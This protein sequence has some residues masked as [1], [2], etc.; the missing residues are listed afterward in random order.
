MGLLDVIFPNRNKNLQAV[1]GYFQTLTAYNPVFTSFEGG[2]YEVMQTRAAIHAFALHCSKLKPEIVGSRNERLARILQHKPNPYMNTAQFLYRVATIYAATN[3]VFIAP[4]YGADYETIIGYYPLSPDRV[5]IVHVH[6]KPYLRYTFANGQKAAVELE[7]A[8]I[9]T[10]MQYKSDFFGESNAEIIDPTLQMIHMQNEGIVN[11]VK[12]GAALRFIA[13]LAQTF[14]PS[15][16]AE[17]R[18]S[19]RESNLSADNNGGF[20][21][22]DG[23]YSDVKQIDSK[24]FIVDAEQM[25]LI[26]ANIFNYFGTNEDILQNKFNEERANAFYEGKIEPFAVNLGLT[27]TN[28]TFTDHAI[29]FGNEIMFSANRLQYASTSAKLQVSQQLFDRGILSQNDVCDIW[30]LPHI[31]GGDRRFIRGEYRDNDEEKQPTPP[32]VLQEPTTPP[33]APNDPVDQT[34]GS[35]GEPPDDASENR[36]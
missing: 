34:N 22:I 14:K 5:E 29:S 26:N 23:K 17:E 35:A 7:R 28:M 27:M 30:Q 25:A 13:R 21:L 19:L 16:L 10:Q 4:I 2:V 3:N 31:E 24:P 36:A 8:G 12:N 18:K 11:A 15:T 6:Q 32:A 33:A 9:M 20:L 1:E